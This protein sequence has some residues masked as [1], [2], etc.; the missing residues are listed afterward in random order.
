MPKDEYW[1]CDGCKALIKK[2]SKVESKPVTVEVTGDRIV[3]TKRYNEDYNELTYDI[4]IL[5]WHLV[6]SFIARIES[7]KGEI[8]E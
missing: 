8:R 1:R 2:G 4:C 6:E 3:N 7:K 5:C